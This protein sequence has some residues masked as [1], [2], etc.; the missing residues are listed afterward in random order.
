MSNIKKRAIGWTEAE[1]NFAARVRIN[2]PVKDWAGR[3]KPDDHPDVIKKRL[4][5]ENP[6]PTKMRPNH[7][8]Q[9]TCHDCAAKYLS[10]AKHELE[11]PGKQSVCMQECKLC[12]AEVE[13]WEYGSHYHTYHAK[14]AKV[15]ERKFD[16]T[17]DKCGKICDNLLLHECEQSRSFSLGYW[18]RG[19]GGK[20][21][22]EGS[23]VKIRKRLK[24]RKEKVLTKE[25][26]V[27]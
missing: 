21:E 27:C 9:F 20:D 23:N 26:K 6:D 8:F 3:K 10:W 24:E 2:K 16:G 1:S 19:G 12:G 7:K 11:C 17:C 5:E 15:V 4:E 13:I 18:V 14:K 25:E 22:R